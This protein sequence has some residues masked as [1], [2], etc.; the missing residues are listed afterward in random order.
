MRP[1]P[2][3]EEWLRAGVEEALA[4]SLGDILHEETIKQFHQA[5]LKARNLKNTAWGW[6]ARF[7]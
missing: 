1:E 3:Y 6:P 5:I 7:D 2:G 4:D